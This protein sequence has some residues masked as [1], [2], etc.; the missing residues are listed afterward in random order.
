MS[1]RE[2]TIKLQLNQIS[3]LIIIFIR[4]CHILT[5]AYKYCKIKYEY[6]LIINILKNNKISSEIS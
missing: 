4:Q 3:H 2:V 6:T 1:S 5:V